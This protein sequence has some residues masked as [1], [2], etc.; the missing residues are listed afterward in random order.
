MTDKEMQIAIAEACGW[1]GIRLRQHIIE[2]WSDILTGIDPTRNCEQAI[3]DYPNDLNAMHEAE[4]VLTAEHQRAYGM[5]LHALLVDVMRRDKGCRKQS[6]FESNA[7]WIWHA[8]AH[9]RAEAFLR[10]IGKWKEEVA[11]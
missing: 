4:K 10:T 7:E 2:G 3:P 6:D 5:E 8:T 9:Q 11:I 1:T